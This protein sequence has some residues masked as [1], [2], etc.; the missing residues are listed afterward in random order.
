M[1]IDISGVDDIML[2]QQEK[3]QRKQKN[4]FEINYKKIWNM[5]R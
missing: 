2:I 5:T 3:M 4:I 1:E